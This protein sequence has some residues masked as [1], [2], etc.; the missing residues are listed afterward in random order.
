MND[1][2]EQNWAIYRRT[3]KA[4]VFL[5]RVK[6]RDEQSAISLAIEKLAVTNRYHQRALIAR[7]AEAMELDEDP[8]FS[9]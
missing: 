2:G 7:K 1:G 8:E 9:E 6:A 5:G 3:P 4:D